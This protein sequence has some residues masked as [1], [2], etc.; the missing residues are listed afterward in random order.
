[1]RK[2]LSSL[3]LIFLFCSPASAYMGIITG[4]DEEMQKLTRA[5]ELSAYLAANPAMQAVT[6]R[7]EACYY[8][9]LTAYEFEL[10]DIIANDDAYLYLADLYRNNGLDKTKTVP[11][12]YFPFTQYEEGGNTFLDLLNQLSQKPFAELLPPIE[13]YEVSIT[14]E[15]GQSLGVANCQPPKDDSRKL[16]AYP[17]N[18]NNIDSYTL[19]L[20]PK[21]LEA[22]Q[23]TP[24]DLNSVKVH[25]VS[26]A[27]HHGAVFYDGKTA[28]F[29]P[30]MGEGWISDSDLYVDTLYPLVE[31]VKVFE[32]GFAS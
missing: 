1:M 14:D 3:L 4:E 17:W 30:V 15:K 9:D 32:K 25:N 21:L 10:A 5:A 23:K 7:L 19:K 6:Q 12:Y 13:V 18:G 2:L 24:L 22:L 31:A 8:V 26:F 16:I 29:T 27:G 28:W 11:V 20:S